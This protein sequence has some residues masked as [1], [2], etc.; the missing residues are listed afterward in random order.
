M[1]FFSATNHGLSMRVRVCMCV[2]DVKLFSTFKEK[3]TDKLESKRDRTTI[4]DEM[5][6]RKSKCTN[7]RTI[8]VEPIPHPEQIVL[9]AHHA[10][11]FITSEYSSSR[12]LNL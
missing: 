4:L 7:F 8:R 3:L 2:F 6:V 1:S 10:A 5:E 9:S 12:S 11:R